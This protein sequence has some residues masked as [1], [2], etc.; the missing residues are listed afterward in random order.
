MSQVQLCH[1]L[2]ALAAGML[3]FSLSVQAADT[4]KVG[5]IGPQSGPFA[6]V[7]M[8]EVHGLQAEFDRINSQGGAVGKRFELVAFDNKSSAQ[9]TTLQVQAAIDQGVRYLFQ[10]AGSNNGHAMNDTVAKYN[11]R[12]PD[13]IALYLNFGALDPALTNEKCQ[14]GSFRFAPHGHMIMTMMIEAV[15]RNPKIK[16]IYLINQDYAWGQSV[17][18]DARAML[19]VKRPDIEI[20]GEDLHPLGKV[21]DFAPY[22]TKIR[23]AKADAVITGNWGNDLALLIKAAKEGGLTT[24]V[25]AP[26]AN[27]LGTPTMMAESGGDRVRAVVFWHPNAETPQFTAYAMSFKAKYKEDFYWLPI[28]TGAEMLRM[29][30]AKAGSDDPLKVA[31]A[32]EGLR[33]NSPIGEMWMRPEDHQLIAPLYQVVFTK[34]GQSGVK[35]D[36]EDTGYGWKTEYRLEMKDFMAPP[37]CK[38]QRP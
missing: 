24:E 34:A 12:N 23:A 1:R 18:K 30:I 19:A 9:E 28:H 14:F 37:T 36:A 31:L 8:A 16:R 17:A 21:K 5:I 15:A 26:I 7:G 4:I 3:S 29:A 11:A 38:V 35:Y 27:L 6:N 2:L 33:Y 20:V 22:V 10:A 32:L 25:D 13:R